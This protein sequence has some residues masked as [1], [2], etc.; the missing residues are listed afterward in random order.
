MMHSIGDYPR[1][2]ILT[3]LAC[4]VAACA[5]KDDVT[6]ADTNRQAFDDLRA[7]IVEVI[8]DPERETEAVALVTA[9]E[10][11]LNALYDMVTNR[12]QRMRDL[13]ADYDSTRA[14]FETFMRD[15]SFEFQADQQQ[16][17]VIHIGLRDVSTAEEWDAISK[18]RT[19]AISNAIKSIKSI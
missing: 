4:A 7:E 15:V 13:N 12:R 5:S 3:T 11:D 17:R 16:I 9:L 6:A 19:K 8:D 1:L 2:L 14:D 10:N 18:A